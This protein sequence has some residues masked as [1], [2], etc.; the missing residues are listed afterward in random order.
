MLKTWS[1]IHFVQAQGSSIPFSTAEPEPEPLNKVGA[2][3]RE[4]ETSTKNCWIVSRVT[5]ESAG[6]ATCTMIN[7]MKDQQGTMILSYNY[8]FGATTSDEQIS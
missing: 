3:M 5:L 7:L 6:T 1:N 2:A 8:F 4:V